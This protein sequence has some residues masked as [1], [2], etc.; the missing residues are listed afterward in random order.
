MGTLRLIRRFEIPI[1]TEPAQNFISLKSDRKISVAGHE[2]SSSESWSPSDELISNQGDDVDSRMNDAVEDYKEGGI[3]NS[4][5]NEVEAHD[6]LMSRERD[7]HKEGVVEELVSEP[8]NFGVNGPLDKGAEVDNF[9][10]NELEHSD[11]LSHVPESC[12]GDSRIGPQEDFHSGSDNVNANGNLV[13]LKGPSAGVQV[14]E[15]EGSPL[16]SSKAKG[17]FNSVKDCGRRVRNTENIEEEIEED[18]FSS[19]LEKAKRR[20]KKLDKKK[21]KKSKSKM[22]KQQLGEV[23]N[24]C[25]SDGD[26]EN[27]NRILMKEAR[28]TWEVGKMLG[29]Y[30]DCDESLILEKFKSMEEDDIAT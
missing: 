6:V 5:L 3:G 20:S 2:S 26:F 9:V 29:I 19:L 4:L 13:L 27:R 30:F 16:H 24:G 25:L 10:V 17:S 28:A 18:W 11:G 12:L 22:S 14:T 7:D 15:R 8:I 23:A 1:S 21:S